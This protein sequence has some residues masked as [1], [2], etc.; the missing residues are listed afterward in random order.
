MPFPTRALT[1]I[2]LFLA[3]LH[4]PAIGIRAKTPSGPPA[5]TPGQV[6]PQLMRMQPPPL[7]TETGVP[8]EPR[9]VRPGLFDHRPPLREQVSPDRA[10][11]AG[12]DDGDLYVRAAGSHEQRILVGAGDGWRW[13]VEG[14]VWSDDAARLAVRRI[15]DHAVPTIPIV[16]WSTETVRRVRYSRVGEAL[17]VHRLWVVERTTGETLEVPHPDGAVYVHALDWS[18][19]GR[20]L[21]FLAADRFVQRL[22]LVEFDVVARTTRRLLREESPTKVVGIEMLHGYADALDDR[23][24][25]VF[26][27]ER[28][29]F[30]WTSERTGER[31]LDLYDADGTLR[32]SLTEGRID[33]WVDRVVGVDRERGLVF[34]AAH[35]RPEDPVGQQLYRVD[36][37]D[38][39]V[40]FLSDGP[41]I[42]SVRRIPGTADLRVVR[43]GLPDVLQ[44]DRITIDG[45]LVETMWRADWSRFAGIE[46]VE[47]RLRLPAA[48]GETELD[49]LLV[50]PP[51]RDPSQRI[52]LVE[53]VYAGPNTTIVPTDP[54]HPWRWEAHFLAHQGYAVVMIDARG[55]PR[56][57]KAFRDFGHG[58]IGQF[59]IADH[60]AAVEHLLAEHPFLDRARVG[61]LGHSWG[62]YFAL[63]AMI[64]APDL[65]RAAVLAAPAVD[66]ADFRVAVEPYMGCLPEDCPEAYAA[67]ANSTRVDRIEGP[68]LVIHGT[69]DDDVPFGESVGLVA[70]LDGAGVPHEFR[71]LPGRN[72]LVQQSRQYWRHTLRFLA[73]HLGR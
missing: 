14:C 50:L 16:D 48:D 18:D 64:Q 55:T 33:G 22:D 1:A 58:R 73:E 47:R 13:D 24:L 15:D 68:L 20:R 61:V 38:G 70:A 60:R 17:T 32:G 72:H 36:L 26:L 35:G 40:R 59:E 57:S 53:I 23:R 41:G 45:R 7:V 69:A 29:T 2:G 52:P 28:G 4:V 25:A 42:E 5:W 21:R 27:D 54:R 43:V 65:Y 30:V 63:R 34:F 37:D 10:W 19:D 12:T 49:A 56:R 67:G 9:V 6:V 31:H 71:V 44:A 39:A 46:R 51:D 3:L 8:V 66:L 62:G 11:L